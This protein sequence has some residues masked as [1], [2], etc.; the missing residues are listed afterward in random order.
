MARSTAAKKLEEMKAQPVL[1]TL[2]KG[3]AFVTENGNL[4]F[5]TLFPSITD[6]KK[7]ELEVKNI[8]G[9]LEVGLFTRRADIYYKAKNDGSFETITFR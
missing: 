2:D 1:R 4:V 6:P 8:A 5:D 3:Y 7:M 9:V